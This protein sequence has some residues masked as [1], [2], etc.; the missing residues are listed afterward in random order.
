MSRVAK[1]ESKA[2]RRVMFATLCLTLVLGAVAVMGGAEQTLPSA[3]ASASTVGQAHAANTF[4]PAQSKKIE[5][6]RE[7]ERTKSG[8]AEIEREISELRVRHEQAA[9]HTEEALLA[10]RAAL[11]MGDAVAA[12]EA[13]E[14]VL[15]LVHERLDLAR[16]LSALAKERVELHGP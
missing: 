16:Q 4:S 8:A 15:E 14:N 10:R 5:H 11:D 12:A 2:V 7:R 9:A 6:A 1:S 3:G 13:L